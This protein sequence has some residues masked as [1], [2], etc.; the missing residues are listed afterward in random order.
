MCHIGLATDAGPVV[1]PTLFGRIDTTLYVHG[2][3]GSRLL[4]AIRD[5]AP[6]SVAA[7]IIDGLV[8]AKSL[9]HHSVNYR[10]VVAFGTGRVLEG[11]NATEGL[12]AI[13]EHSAPGRWDDARRPNDKEMRATTVIAIDIDEASAKFRTGPPSDDEEDLGYP[14]WTGIVP[15]SLQR[16]EPEPDEHANVPL[17]EYLR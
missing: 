14:V 10:S 9:F 16:G 7:S 12:R 11:E 1:I 5:G 4:R 2:S 6:V 8:L 15:V 13:T 17:P 3:P